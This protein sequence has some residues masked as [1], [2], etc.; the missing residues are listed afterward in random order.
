MERNGKIYKI[1][2]TI[3]DKIYIGSTQSQYISK[4]MAHHREN[5]I[6][7]PTCGKLYPAMTELGFD[8][9]KILLLESFKF[10]DKEELRAKEYEWIVKL[11]SVNSGYNTIY[12]DGILPEASRK[13]KNKSLSKYYKEANKDVGLY[14]REEK[15]IRPRWI[16]TWTDNGKLKSKSFFIDKIENTDKIKEEARAYRNNMIKDLELYN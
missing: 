11:D 9:F 7:E 15:G 6:K 8:K 16:S 2:N 3:N 14:F 5:C 1:V 13:Q 4:R 12:K 10:T